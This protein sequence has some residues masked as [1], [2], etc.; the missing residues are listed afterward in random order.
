MCFTV[1]FVFAKSTKSFPVKEQ[2]QINISKLELYDALGCKG[3]DIG[4]EGYKGP[5]IGKEGYKGPDIGK[6]SI[7]DY[8][9]FQVMF[10]E[11]CQIQLFKG[12][13]MLCCKLK[14]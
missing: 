4:K 7:S 10:C 13:D 9:C 11:F 6:G 5:G 1:S 12:L 3:P 14:F 8:D 2:I